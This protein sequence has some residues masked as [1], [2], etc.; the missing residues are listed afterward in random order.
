MRNFFMASLW[1]AFYAGAGTEFLKHPQWSNYLVVINLYHRTNP[2][3]Y[4]PLEL[5]PLD[6]LDAKS[7]ENE[8]TF[9][10]SEWNSFAS[11]RKGSLADRQIEKKLSQQANERLYNLLAQLKLHK[12]V[13][14]KDV[15]DN[16]PEAM[17]VALTP[18]DSLFWN[19]VLAQKIKEDLKARQMGIQEISR[20]EIK[21]ESGMLVFS[22][23]NNDSLRYRI[24]LESAQDNSI[25]LKSS[26]QDKRDLSSDFD[27]PDKV[28]SAYSLKGSFYEKKDSESPFGSYPLK[29]EQYLGEDGARH[30]FGDGHKH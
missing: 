8:I 16:M 15:V 9:T 28:L 21:A 23:K 3:V 22:F 6:R 25:K 27:Q 17:R 2:G 5:L 18:V 29:T 26:F 4:R 10:A 30:F 7:F 24:Q 13:A 19:G 20:V 11:K 14:I 1:M 12:T